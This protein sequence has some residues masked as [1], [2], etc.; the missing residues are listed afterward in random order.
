[1]DGLSL[2][3][4]YYAQAGAPLL[5]SRFPELVP[6][7][8][9][10][11]V[12][13]GSDCFGYDDA[14]SRDHDWGPAFCLWLD[15][16][17][18]RRYARTL[19]ATLSSLPPAWSGVPTRVQAMVRGHRVG[20]LATG[21]FY[22]S[23]T[24]WDRPAQ[25][26]HEWLRVSESALAACTNGRVFTDPSGA[27]TRFRN[28]LLAHYPEPVRLR[29]LEARCQGLAQSGQYNLLR[30]LRRGDLVAARLAEAEFVRHAISAAHLLARRYRP[31]YKWMHRSLLTLDGPGPA[32]HPLI[33]RLLGPGAPSHQATS[34]LVEAICALLIRELRLQGLTHATDGFLLAHA[35]ELR[36]QIDPSLLDLDPGLE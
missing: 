7:I 35:L 11:L 6:R 10:G 30:S 8:A 3:A 33:E 4:Q 28:A 18:F 12:G 23:F 15:E 2:S 29:K 36:G 16:E 9:A 19:Q 1:M 26:L 25:L 14:W 24:G 22:R 5:A 32:L 17:D 13:E 21:R 34:G 27:F 20:V 31:F